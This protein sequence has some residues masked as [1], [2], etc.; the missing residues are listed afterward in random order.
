M[1]PENDLNRKLIAIGLTIL[2]A[3]ILTIW[4]IYGIGEYG[5]ALFILT[6][7]FIGA[8]SVLLYGRK[9]NL[10][11]GEAYSIAFTTLGLFALGLLVFAIEG[12]I[13]I[14][15][16]APL[17]LLFTWIGALIGL[18]INNKKP[19]SSSVT[20]L[21][22]IAAIPLTAFVE[23][24]VELDLISVTTS[25]E[26]NA[27]PETVWKNV[28]EF[29]DLKEPTEFLFNAG[30]SYP[31]SA[32]IDG[33]GIGAVR[34][35]N[36]TTG[37]F[38]EPITVWDKPNL[39][40]FDVEESP[41]PMTELNFWDIDAPHLHDFFLSRKGQFRLTELPNGNTLLEGTT[42][43]THKIK[44]SFYWQLWSNHIVHQIHQRVLVHIKDNSENNQ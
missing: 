38:V 28:I 17:A 6:P 12:V 31:T 40:K 13:C 2:I 14:A 22:I 35:C 25:I 10:T 3:G 5:M 33:I 26:I 8:S 11:K 30:I 19:E 16:S 41:S 21:L 39:L 37:S 9:K 23:K 1:L 20:L 18:N 4:G 42:W 29:P 34:H 36:F 32:E 27:T 24:D 7:F 44:P 15:M 43:Y